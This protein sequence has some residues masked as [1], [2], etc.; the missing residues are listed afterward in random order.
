[1]STLPFIDAGVERIPTSDGAGDH[2]VRKCSLALPAWQ[3]PPLPDT[4]GEKPVVD[5][6]GQPLF[7]EL[8]ILRCL[9]RVGWQGV[10]VDT[11]RGVFR[12]GLPGLSAPADLPP[13][14]RALFDAIA[15]RNGGRRGCWDVYV[16][17]DGNVLFAE[18]KRRGRDRIAPQSAPVAWG[19]AQGRG[20]ARRVHR[21]RMEP[22][23][24]KGDRLPLLS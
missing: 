13:D 18:A 6:E 23:P 11:Y 19:C 22:Q 2:T 7:A 5:L 20:S 3:G 1:M 16:W 10:W 8:A 12:C 17:Y 15:Q 9:E 24:L 21:R 14:R 4:Y